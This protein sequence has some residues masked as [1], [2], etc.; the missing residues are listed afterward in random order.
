MAL[1]GNGV[2]QS[3]MAL[4]KTGLKWCSGGGD[5][6]CFMRSVWEI[7]LAVWGGEDMH[8]MPRFDLFLGSIQMQDPGICW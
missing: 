7:L 2:V 5:D 4:C 3:C 1:H 6:S 8:G